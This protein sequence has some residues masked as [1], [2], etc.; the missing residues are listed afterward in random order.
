M[1]FSIRSNIFHSIPN[2]G[3]PRPDLRKLK[4]LEEGDDEV[5]LDILSETDE[6]E[7]LEFSLEHAF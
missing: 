7:Y 2:L 1:A 6:D 5:Y 3:A 4:V